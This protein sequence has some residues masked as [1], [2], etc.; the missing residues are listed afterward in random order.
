MCYELVYKYACGRTSLIKYTI[1]PE[2]VEGG[3]T[4]WVPDHCRFYEFH[5][6]HYN[7]ECPNCEE[8]ADKA[9]AEA[10]TAREREVRELR[11]VEDERLLFPFQ[12]IR[13][14]CEK[15]HLSEDIIDGAQGALRLIDRAEKDGWTKLIEIKYE[16]MIFICIFVASDLLEIDFPHEMINH[17]THDERVEFY[18]SFVALCKLAETK[19][20]P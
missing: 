9:A 17:F 8:A 11:E 18:D 4:G 16:V 5:V 10:R 19:G 13:E 6:H 15:F 12:D 1:T 7:M 20:L 14:K 3:I 2:H